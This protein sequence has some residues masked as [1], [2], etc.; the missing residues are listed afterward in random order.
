MM[1]R[2]KKVNAVIAGGNRIWSIAILATPRY[3]M[4]ACPDTIQQLFGE[5][6]H[7]QQQIKADQSHGT[8]AWV[9]VRSKLMLLASPPSRTHTGTVD[10]MILYQL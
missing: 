3:A 8:K 6:M 10:S 2:Q 7:D 9:R 5:S 1:V 4:V